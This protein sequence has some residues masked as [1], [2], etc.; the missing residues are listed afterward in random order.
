MFLRIP[1]GEANPNY[2]Q[3]TKCSDPPKYE[4]I[5]G[6]LSHHNIK[7]I[8]IIHGNILLLRDDFKIN[9]HGHPTIQP[10]KFSSQP[11]W[12]TWCFPCCHAA[13]CEIRASAPWSAGRS[14]LLWSGISWNPTG[15]NMWLPSGNLTKSY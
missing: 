2:L 5:S 4:D 1:T 7:S 10:G 9:Q 11:L 15:K 13:R 3:P 12:I 6:R 14:G 8:H